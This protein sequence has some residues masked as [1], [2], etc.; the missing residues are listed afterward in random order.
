MNNIVLQT[1]TPESRARS[2]GDIL[3]ESGRL[4]R[5]DVARITQRQQQDNTPFGEAAVALQLLKREDIVFALAKQYDYAYLPEGD[6]S[7]SPDVIAAY[8]P[9]SAVGEKLRAIRSQL[10]L[11]WFNGDPLRKVVTVVSPA[12]GEGRSFIAAN[13][14]VVFAQQGQR[15][16]LID[17]DLRGSRQNTLFR[18][19]KSAGLSG[20]LAERVA[21]A[22]VIVTL[23]SLP[24][25]S[26]LPAGPQ[27]PNPQELLGRPSFGLLLLQVINQFDVVIIDTPAGNQCADAEIIS[28][29]AG[30]AVMVVRKDKS[31]LPDV[32]NMT[33]RLRD[34]GVAMVGSILNEV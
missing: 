11:R 4:T 29:R 22:D 3:V 5:E 26:V 23:N 6:T 10:N 13:L 24:T 12:H 17:G 19:G 30:A 20:V 28:A 14:A 18:T 15:T 16:L 31:L 8:K 2:I 34:S 7:L 32:S 33:R 25:L 9:F 27:P 21:P 1:S